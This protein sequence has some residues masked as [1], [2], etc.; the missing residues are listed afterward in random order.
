MAVM[1]TLTI[2]GTTYTVARV[3]PALS[4][5]LLADKWVSNGDRY[6]QVVEV[7]GV[8]NRSKVDLQ[9]TPEQLGEFHNKI[10]GFTTKN[11]GGVVTAYAIGDR[12]LG[13]HTI[14]V[15]LTEV[16]GV[17]EVLGNTV[18]TTMPRANLEQDDPTKADYVYGKDT[19][20]NTAIADALNKAKESVEYPDD[21][22]RARFIQAMLEK[23]DKIG[24][25]IEINGAAGYPENNY[26]NGKSMAKLYT[27]ANGYHE[28]SK[29]WNTPHKVIYTKDVESAVNLYSSVFYN[30]SSHFAND[31]TA[32]YFMHGGKT[33]TTGSNNRLLGCI[34]KAPGDRQFVAWLSTKAMSESAGN[35]RH[36][37]MKLLMDIAY[38]RHKD[39]AADVSALEAQ[40]VAKGVISAVVMLVPQCAN[41]M[42]YE[43]FDF[44]ETEMTEGDL[45]D[46]TL[47]DVAWGGKTYREIFLTSNIFAAG[48]ATTDIA[49]TDW[50]QYSNFAKPT[51]T[52]EHY[53]TSPSAWNC[54]GTTSVQMYKELSLPIG[55]NFYIACKRKLTSYTAGRWCGIEVYYLGGAGLVISDTADA[56]GVSETFET[57]SHTFTPKTATTQ[58]WV[59]SG[60]SANLTGYIDDIVCV[61]MTDLFGDN[62]P[63]KTQMNSLY[64]NFL[65]LY[66]GEVINGLVEQYKHE[67]PVYEYRADD[68][69][70]IASNTK[71]LTAITALDYIDNLDEYLTIKPSDIQPG[72]GPVFEGGERMTMRDALYALMLPS[73]NTCAYAI[74]RVI[75]NK[76]LNVYRH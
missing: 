63:S 72:S 13:D 69:V 68:R 6:S 59:G 14:Q 1:K 30:D 10:L 34:M 73:S 43:Q 51:P 53:N 52:T 65:K 5:T 70:N 3:V 54:S 61:N 55:D 9:P 8:T 50:M 37:C 64:E 49:N 47:D 26:S 18:G 12:P 17:G 36:A 40:M 22:A 15:T 74:A 2:N 60:G 39:P 29:I 75:G 35:N 31:L 38:A 46:A 16:E 66:K 11:N 20:L 56:N 25:D 33:G 27:I 45:A 24:L 42:T 71:T 41:L 57:F 23:A 4:V 76:L 62:T 28:L 21:D 7:E 44:F 19:F 67:Y 48:N 32:H 58:I